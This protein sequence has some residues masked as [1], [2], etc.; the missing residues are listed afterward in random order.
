MAEL[1]LKRYILRVN[2]SL[3]N[4]SVYET[5]AKEVFM[6]HGKEEVL[7]ILEPTQANVPAKKRKPPEK[8]IKDKILVEVYYF[9]KGRQPD[10]L[11][12]DNEFTPYIFNDGILAGIGW[13]MLGGHKSNLN[14]SPD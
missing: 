1:E 13:T 14:F 5:A 7:R 3:I 9:H 4:R 12:T 6:G 11:S 8:Y 2:T 10:G